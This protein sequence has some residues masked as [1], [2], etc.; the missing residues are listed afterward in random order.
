MTA[1]EH[2]QTLMRERRKFPRGSAEHNWRTRAA[3][4]YF[5][6]LRGIPTS[7]WPA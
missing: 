7:E 3:R 4:R 5:W 1:R 6:L 2:F